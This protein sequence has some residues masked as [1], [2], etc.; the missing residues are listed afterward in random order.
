MLLYL[1][2]G[3]PAVLILWTILELLRITAFYNYT[4]RV[5]DQRSDQRLA[6]IREGRDPRILPRCRVSE[7]W[8][9]FDSLPFWS[10]NFEDCMVF[11]KDVSQR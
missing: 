11:E 5:I 8:Q 4:M 2:I 9:R 7:S 6:L 10:W 1:I 3:L